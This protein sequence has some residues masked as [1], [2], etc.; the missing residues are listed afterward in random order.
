VDVAVG[1]TRELLAAS[2]FAVAVSGTVTLEAAWFGVPMV[3]VYRVS[4][5][6]YQLVGRWLLRTPH[7][8]LVNILAG[9]R[10]VPELMPWHGSARR[11]ADT[12][13]EVMND[14]GWLFETR[15]ALTALTDPLR[16]PPPASAS[17]NAA[18][19]ALRTVGR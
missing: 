4:R 15:K 11:V 2:H 7:L 19:L 16:V 12:V 17:D 13:R 10:L 8:S 9:R 3:I 1:R 6:G 14:Y 18:A 5:V